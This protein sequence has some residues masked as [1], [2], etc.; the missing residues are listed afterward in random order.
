MMEEEKKEVEKL[1]RVTKTL[2][3]MELN[4]PLPLP[5]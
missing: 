1:K 5:E 3:A 4:T 2:K